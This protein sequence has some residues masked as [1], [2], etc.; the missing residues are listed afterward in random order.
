MP[1]IKVNCIVNCNIKLSEPTKEIFLNTPLAYN[2]TLAHAM[3][4]TVYNDDGTEALFAL[5]IAFSAELVVR[6]PA[7]L[8]EEE[9]PVFLFL[10]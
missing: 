8:I 3:R 2:N 6:D 4:V 10:F 1:D 5:T 9:A 7:I